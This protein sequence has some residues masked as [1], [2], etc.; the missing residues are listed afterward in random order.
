[1]FKDSFIQDFTLIRIWDEDGTHQQNC[2]KRATVINFFLIHSFND[3]E[4]DL[5]FNKVLPIFF[6]KDNVYEKL[7]GPFYS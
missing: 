2:L 5:L 3:Y 4:Y 6:F 7:V 1:M